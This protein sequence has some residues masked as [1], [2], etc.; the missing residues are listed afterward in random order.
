MPHSLSILPAVAATAILAIA[1]IADVC[2]RDIRRL[3]SGRSVVLL[4]IASW[5]LFE[6]LTLSPEV[7]TYDQ[8]QYN[9]GIVCVVLAMAGFL[10]G[11]HGSAGCKLFEPIAARVQIL[12]NPRVLWRLVVFCAVVGFGRSS[13]IR[14]MQ[15]IDLLHGILGMRETWG[16]LIGRGATAVFYLLTLQLELLAFDGRGLVWP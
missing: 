4:G 7:L 5:Y 16:G 3:V 15:L 9:F 12:D 6:A 2:C 8:G 13:F 14:W 10:A 11:Y 1:L